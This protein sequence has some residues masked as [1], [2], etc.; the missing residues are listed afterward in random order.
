VRILDTDTC[1]E[2]LRG[3]ERVI[4]R[5]RRTR[6]LVATTWITAGELYFGA[7][8]S[9]RP[10]TNRQ[11]VDEFLTTLDVLGL[12]QS[13]ARAFG[14]NKG[15]LETAGQIIPDA[16]LWIGAIAIATGGTIVTGNT[17]HVGRMAGVKTEDWIR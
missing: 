11:V 17:R 14:I 12:D 9:Q 16:D 5:R 7:A 13:A 15:L 1:I 4:E 8:K 3:N 2:L 6:D 10:E